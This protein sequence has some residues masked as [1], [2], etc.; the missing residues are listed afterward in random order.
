LM[1]ESRHESRVG[2]NAKYTSTP[3]NILED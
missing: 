2:M 1:V 3:I